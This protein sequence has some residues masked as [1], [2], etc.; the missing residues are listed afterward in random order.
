MELE[1]CF[2]ENRISDVMAEKVLKGVENLIKELLNK[3]QEISR[4]E[5]GTREFT[6]LYTGV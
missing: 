5:L 2:W 1:L 3:K 6:P 4:L